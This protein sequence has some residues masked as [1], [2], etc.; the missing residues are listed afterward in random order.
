MR[1]CFLFFLLFP[2]MIFSADIDEIEYSL[3]R[4]DVL[5]AR[6]LLGEVNSFHRNSMDFALLA[7]EIYYRLDA[8]D[9]SLHWALQIV[10]KNRLD[11][12]IS[13]ML[14]RY[15]RRYPSEYASFI[16]GYS[17]YSI[18]NYSRA[19]TLFDQ[20]KS[21]MSEIED[22]IDYYK[23]SSIL[24]SGDTTTAINAAEVFLNDY[25][26]VLVNRV[27]L[28]LGEIY[29]SQGNFD[30]ALEIFKK[31]SPDNRINY[32]I[33]KLFI[34]NGEL[35]SAVSYLN[36]TLSCSNEWSDS[37]WYCLM[38]INRLDTLIRVRSLSSRRNYNGVISLLLPYIEDHPSNTEALYLLGRS[39]RK[40][41]KYD[42][43]LVY[44]D[45]A[46]SGEFL[47]KSL[48]NMGLC[49]QSLNRIE[50]EKELW[51]K[52]IVQC[53]SG[54]LYDDA[55]YYLAKICLSQS[56][57]NDAKRHLLLILKNPGLNDM[58]GQATNILWAMMNFDQRKEFIQSELTGS[59][60]NDIIPVIYRSAELYSGEIREK[61]F[62]D[63]IKFNYWGEYARRAEKN[64]S[65]IGY[66]PTALPVDLYSN[67]EESFS[68]YN[69]RSETLEKCRRAELLYSCG[70]RDDAR[71]EISSIENPNPAERMLIAK[72]A[73]YCGDRFTAIRNASRLMSYFDEEIPS[74]LFF[75][76][77]PQAYRLIIE[78]YAEKYNISVSIIQGLVRTESLFDHKIRS[79]AGAT[80]LAQ[81]MPSTA[82]G[83]ARNIGLEEYDIE[84][85]DH[86]L[87][88][89]VYYLKS[90]YSY[91]GRMEV[92]IAAYNAGPG[93]AKRWTDAESEEDFIDNISF[94]ETRAYVPKVL[95]TA[96]IYE[97]VDRR[98]F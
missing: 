17:L 49:Y 73:D 94:S 28:L 15:S 78:N 3:N 22:Y 75:T 41:K 38:G 32:L 64:L 33:G 35:N 72:T 92:A 65:Q 6:R 89:G 61:I 29:Y 10:D 96:R 5:L 51:G 79:W 50:E 2:L 9:S 25:N 83:V 48:F 69:I 23:I 43:A 95:S 56:D 30:R 20:S 76:V 18:G 16:D 14:H 40:E 58:A 88:M 45:R 44:L 24:K 54:N 59:M 86:N 52:F 74:D 4:G 27:S 81:L 26:S 68:R 7:T 21:V 71:Y 1:Y 84:D 39:Y 53:S 80:G 70:L 46:S 47:C 19:V 8:Y 87:Y 62:F 98:E 93:N 60:S 66:P 67:A 77:Y 91:F 36:I 37:A 82:A 34:K 42:R 57:S 63:I 97:K 11:P 90:Q 31:G 85:P 12:V 55:L 13:A